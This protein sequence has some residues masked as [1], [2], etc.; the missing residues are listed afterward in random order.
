MI[1]NN[2]E[3]RQTREQL[4][5]LEQNL[6][7]LYHEVYYINSARF[8]LM[9]EA[10]ID[11][12][13]D[14]RS[15]ID[16]YI[17][18]AGYQDNVVDI[19]LRLIGPSAQLGVT[20]VSLLIK[21]LDNFRKGVRNIAVAIT[22]QIP[23]RGMRIEKSIEASCDFVIAGLKP[24]SL[25]VGLDTPP[26]QQLDLLSNVADPAKRAINIFM[27]IVQWTMSTDLTQ[28]LPDFIKD[29]SARDFILRQVLNVAPSA[30]VPVN[31]I[32]F[33]GSL[34]RKPCL[35]KLTR[36]SRKRLTKLIV[37][38]PGGETLKAVG[39][40]REI[41]LDKLTFFLRERPNNEPQINCKVIEDII[42]EARN[43]LG[44]EVEVEGV[45]S[46][47]KNGRVRFLLVK[48]LEILSD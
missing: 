4:L 20:S 46:R 37:A 48:T 12:I 29:L 35:P 6:E 28:Q 31:A 2:E 19:W 14:L 15:Q 30:N 47:Y 13:H 21:I 43:A 36:E 16:Q 11:H 40:I 27:D 39:V 17:G 23:S 7:S 3:L 8:Y 44:K 26:E 45:V 25:Q 42:D 38:Q 41:D 1:T 33:S 32:E 24:G 10:Y 22:D 5:C 18:I 34:I 9:A